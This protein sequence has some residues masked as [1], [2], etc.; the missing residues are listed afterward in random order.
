MTIALTDLLKSI[1]GLVVMS[2]ELD[3]LFKCIYEARVPGA[4]QRVGL[5][6]V[7]AESSLSVVVPRRTHR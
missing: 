4:W 1:Q 6:P 2:A 3:D 5:R 7:H